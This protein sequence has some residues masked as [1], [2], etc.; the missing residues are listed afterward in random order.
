MN[1]QQAFAAL[2]ESSHLC[3]EG[4]QQLWA[5]Q[6][7]EAHEVLW[8]ENERLRKALAEIVD[9]GDYV[10]KPHEFALVARNVLEESN[11]GGAA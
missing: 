3:D 4:G 8:A 1:V 5:S 2:Q 6:L 11:K 10:F 9:M 7:H